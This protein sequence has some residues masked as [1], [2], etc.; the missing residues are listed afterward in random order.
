MGAEM[1]LVLLAVAACLGAC[2]AGPSQAAGKFDCAWKATPGVEAS[3]DGGPEIDIE[4]ISRAMKSCGFALT[5]ENARRL[6][7]YF[8]LRHHLPL[9]AAKVQAAYPAAL[10]KLNAG[11]DRLAP[12]ER[13][14]LMHFGETRSLSGPLRVRLDQLI[15]SAGIPATDAEARLSAMRYILARVAMAELEAQD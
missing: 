2:H 9:E 7:L 1:R 4:S 10:G 5:G 13:T 3:F 11:M 15:S 8:D 12:I 6:G 14:E